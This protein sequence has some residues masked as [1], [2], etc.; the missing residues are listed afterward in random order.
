MDVD[1]LVV[2]SR[3]YLAEHNRPYAQNVP[4]MDFITAIDE[5]RPQVLIGATGA[6]NAFTPEVIGRAWL[7]TMCGRL[8]LPCLT[9][10]QMLN[11]RQ[12]KPT[13]ESGPSHFLPA[14]AHFRR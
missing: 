9:R 14:A 10:P 5:I 3:S 6:A 7:N 12:A 13:S 2:S 4:A 8:F 1:G 11:A